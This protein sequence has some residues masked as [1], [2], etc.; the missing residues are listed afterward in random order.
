MKLEFEV[1]LALLGLQNLQAHIFQQLLNLNFH[2]TDVAKL[3]HQRNL[4][5]QVC[6]SLNANST[7]VD[8]M[9]SNRKTHHMYLVF[10]LPELDIPFE[11]NLGTSDDPQFRNERENYGLVTMTTT[12][13]KLKTLWI[14]R[15]CY[16]ST[17]DLFY[18]IPEMIMGLKNKR[19][20]HSVAIQCT[21]GTECVKADSQN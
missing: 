10:H 6:R 19:M 9:L 2:R 1:R 8:T 12:A 15:I 14:A 18:R 16:C 4:H 21:F 5:Y 11:S 17:L 13:W 20:M 3:L 7:N